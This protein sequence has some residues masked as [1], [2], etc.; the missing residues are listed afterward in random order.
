MGPV[1][2]IVLGRQ[3]TEADRAHVDQFLQPLG[4]R[5]NDGAEADEVWIR[6]TKPIGGTYEGEPRLF[7][8][9]WQAERQDEF[10]G[11]RAKLEERFG[12]T[13]TSCLAISAGMSRPMDHRVLG[14]LALHLG[15][16]LE[17]VIDFDGALLPSALPGRFD[18]ASWPEVAELVREFLSAVPGKVI[19]ITYQVN[20]ER[21]WACHVADCEFMQGWLQHPEFHMIK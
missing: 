15:R 16:V 11:R 21:T 7:A 9:E 19:T 1:V 3:L 5:G 20:D 13:P 14:E 2:S 18:R 17:G 10:P 4:E 8:F 6:T 12:L